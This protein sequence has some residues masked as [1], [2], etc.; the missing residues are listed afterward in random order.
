MTKYA[1]A[2][3]LSAGAGYSIDGGQL[4]GLLISSIPPG[5]IDT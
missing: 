3:S 1:S 5:G 4:S 2:F